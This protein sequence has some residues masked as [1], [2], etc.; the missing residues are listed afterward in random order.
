MS[1]LPAQ[2]VVALFVAGDAPRSTAAL[3]NLSAVL[4]AIGRPALRVDVFDVLRDP[5]K[6]LEFGLLATPSLCVIPAE[7]RRRWYVGD[8]GRADALANWLADS[9]GCA[10]GP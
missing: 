6:A 2:A 7:G 10:P 1:A 4:G 9:L 3:R 5:A 8:L